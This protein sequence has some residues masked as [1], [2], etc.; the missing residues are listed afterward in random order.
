MFTC[1]EDWK[2]SITVEAITVL[3]LIVTGIA[4]IFV[5]GG[6]EVTKLIAA[7]LI[8]FLAREATGGKKDE[9]TS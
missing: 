1:P 9:T 3:G 6:L 7:G 2:C 4:S 8:G 5:S